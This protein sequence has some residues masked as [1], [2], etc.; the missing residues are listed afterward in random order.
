MF[1]VFFALPVIGAIFLSGMTTYSLGIFAI[2]GGFMLGVL[3]HDQSAFVRA[4]RE[5]VGDFVVVFFLPIFFTYTGLRTNI[6]EMRK[7]GLRPFLV[8]AVGEVVI[9]ALT[10]GLV[11]GASR[12]IH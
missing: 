11:L 4:W 5:K 12:F 3:L 7:Q 2:F 9:A 1:L 10:L 8:D 6:G